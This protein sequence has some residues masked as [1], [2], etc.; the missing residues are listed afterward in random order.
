ME[1][2]KDFTVVSKEQWNL[3]VSLYTLPNHPYYT[4]KRAYENMGVGIRTFVDTD[5]Q[6]V[7]DLMKMTSL[8]G[9]SISL[10]S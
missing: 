3:L 2:T 4:I 7:N 6:K 5:Y 9:D 8:G 1:K 10:S